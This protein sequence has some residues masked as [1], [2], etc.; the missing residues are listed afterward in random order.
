MSAW[1]CRGCT[2]VYAV[3]A[4]RCPHCGVN[5]PIDEVEQLRRE[6][7]AMPKITVHGGPSNADVEEPTPDVVEPTE[8]PVDDAPVVEET[9]AVEGTAPEKASAE[10]AKPRATRKSSRS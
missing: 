7:E 8:A 10:E 6:N 5:D 1:E 4:P 2:A 9:P 3:D